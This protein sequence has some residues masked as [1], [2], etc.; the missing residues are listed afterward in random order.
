MTVYTTNEWDPPA[1]LDF[2]CQECGAPIDGEGW[3]TPCAKSIVKEQ[4][5]DR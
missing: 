4:N 5:S 2:E 3:C 1:P